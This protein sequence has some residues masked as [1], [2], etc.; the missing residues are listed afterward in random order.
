M[1]I[2]HHRLALL[3]VAAAGLTA[4]LA[5]AGLPRGVKLVADDQIADEA[6]GTTIANGRAELSVERQNIH[7]RADSIEVRPGI[8]EVLFKGSAEITSGRAVYRGD[9][10]SCTLDFRRCVPVTAD[11]PL[12][13]SAAPETVTVPR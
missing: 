7:G 12:P 4:S 10:I 9:T 5:H 1:P 8:D 11:Q 13:A 2:P 6:T 3:A